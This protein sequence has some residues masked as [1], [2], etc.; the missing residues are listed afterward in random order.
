MHGKLFLFAKIIWWRVSIFEKCEKLLL[1][2]WRFSMGLRNSLCCKWRLQG[3]WRGIVACTKWEIQKRWL[4]YQMAYQNSHNE[5]QTSNGLGLIYQH[6][7]LYRNI[8]FVAINSKWLLQD[9]SLLLCCKS[10]RYIRK[11]GLRK[12]V[13]GCFK[14]GRCWSV[15]NG[16][17]RKRKFGT[18]GGGLE[19]AKKSG[20]QSSGRISV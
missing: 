15:P 10:F 3:G 19:L 16:D 11:I 8:Q 7:D 20:Q 4:L 12:L 18:F 17:C 2:R 1:E 14:R 9:G 13:W 5:W 6:G